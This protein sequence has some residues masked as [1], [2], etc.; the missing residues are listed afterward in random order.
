M[1]AYGHHGEGQIFI[2]IKMPDNKYHSFHG[3]N[4]NGNV[5]TLLYVNGNDEAFDIVKNHQIVYA[6]DAAMQAML[7]DRK[8]RVLIIEPGV[9]H[10][11]E[12]KRYS[13][14][15][16]YSILDPD[17]TRPYIVPG[18]D[19]FD[20]IVARPLSATSEFFVVLL[21]DNLNCFYCKSSLE[22]AIEG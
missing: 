15:T 5:G 11:F 12:H 9:G 2:G 8:G 18:D 7:S 13:L 4:K 10:R 3:V 1:D 16:N 21:S 14:M 6:K 22:I 19:R 20:F 17:I